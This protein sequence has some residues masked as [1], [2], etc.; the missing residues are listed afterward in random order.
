M[1]YKFFDNAISKWTP[2][3]DGPIFTKKSTK[4]DV[5]RHSTWFPA[6]FLSR[7]HTKTLKQYLSSIQAFEHTAL[8]VT[9][10]T[11]NNKW[12]TYEELTAELA[13]RPHIPNKK[14]G[15][16]LRRLAAQGKTRQFNQLKRR[17]NKVIAKV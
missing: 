2:D 17:W 12:V 8:E 11:N 15:K 5:L 16:Y 1:P 6:E 14:E 4:F 7:C 13:K 3:G 9:N 10:N